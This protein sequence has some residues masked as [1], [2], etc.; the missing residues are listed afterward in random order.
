MV[1]KDYGFR[2][3]RL[4]D[5]QSIRSFTQESQMAEQDNDFILQPRAP[6]FPTPQPSAQAVQDQRVHKAH[7]IQER[8]K[9]K[10]VKL[11]ETKLLIERKRIGPV[12][13]AK[14]LERLG[15]KQPNKKSAL[16]VK[17]MPF[18]PQFRPDG[19]LITLKTSTN[20]LHVTKIPLT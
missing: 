15:I 7:L 6:R 2:R 14:E 1:I 17:A 5:E 19:S 12:D 10:E 13:I 4:P 16:P 9:L 8:I 18:R 11:H 20:Q 3:K